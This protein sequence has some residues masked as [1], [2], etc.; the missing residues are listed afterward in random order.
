MFIY[1]V[2]INDNGNNIVGDNVN[3]M[4]NENCCADLIQDDHSLF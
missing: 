1:L 2:G 4:D 3:E